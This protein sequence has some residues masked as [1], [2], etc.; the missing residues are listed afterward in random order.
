M[1]D[2]GIAR[3]EIPYLAVIRERDPDYLK[4][5]R[6]EAEYKFPGRVFTA[7][8]SV[9]GPYNDDPNGDMIAI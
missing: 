5:R 6:E 2:D 3:R 9:R 4:D 8:Q 1:S 7:D